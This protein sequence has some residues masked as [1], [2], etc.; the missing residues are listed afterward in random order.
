[1][2]LKSILYS[3]LSVLLFYALL[4][5]TVIL[6][7]I[8]WLLGLLGIVMVLVI[9]PILTRRAIVAACGILDKLIAKYIVPVLMLIGIVAV[10]LIMFLN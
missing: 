1:M 8:Y 4:A 2:S 9:P 6:F 7:S 10:L 5:V 3:I